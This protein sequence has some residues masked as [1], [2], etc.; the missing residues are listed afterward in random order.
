MSKDIYLVAHGEAQHHVQGLVGGWYDS[1]LT[2]RGHRQ[3]Q[4]IADSLAQRLAGAPAVEVYSSDLRRTAQTAAPIAKALGVEAIQWS[5]LRERSYGEAGGQ[6]DAWLEERTV[7]APKDGDRLDHRD[8]LS[9]AET[10]REFATRLYRAM[11]AVAASPCPVQVV[12][13]HGYAVTFAIAAWIRMPLESVGWVNFRSA[14][15][16]ISHLREDDRWFNRYLMSLSET[17]HLA[18]VD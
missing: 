15:G 10:K 17:G 13:T 7:L 9:E 16:A 4:A 3:A 18:G 1:E 2:E 6:P 12:V 14:S 8:G 11:D 5:D